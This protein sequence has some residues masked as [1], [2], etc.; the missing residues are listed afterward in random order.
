VDD[1]GDF[2]IYNFDGNDVPRFQDNRTPDIVVYFFGIETAIRDRLM[3][4]YPEGKLEPF[5]RPGAPPDDP[6]SFYRYCIEGRSLRTDPKLLFRAVNIPPRQWRRYYY[7]FTFGLGHG[8]IEKE[9]YVPD[10]L[11]PSPLIQFALTAVVWGPII[12]EKDGKYVFTAKGGNYAVL[13]IGDK[14]VLDYRPSATHP[15]ESRRVV[16]L[17]AGAYHSYLRCYFRAGLFMPTVEVLR[18]GETQPVPLGSLPLL[19]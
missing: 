8:V 11:Q 7:P 10:A 9:E 12:I 1:V 4:E 5:K 18:P 13:D 15:G 19:F 6:P 14:R 16:K 17:K 3:R 2:M